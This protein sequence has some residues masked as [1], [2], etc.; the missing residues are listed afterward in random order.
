MQ[1]NTHKQRK[2][3]Q[4]KGIARIID[5]ITGKCSILKGFTNLIGKLL[6]IKVNMPILKVNAQK[7][8]ILHKTKVITN[9]CTCI[10]FIWLRFYCCT[11]FTCLGFTTAGFTK[12]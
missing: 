5:N 2:F 9:I 11:G 3:N 10:C 4:M 7:C 1:V 6:T 12:H 8:L